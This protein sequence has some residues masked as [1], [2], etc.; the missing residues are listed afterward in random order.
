MGK[1]GKWNGN[2]CQ[3]LEDLTKNKET[4]NFENGGYTDFDD[5]LSNIFN[6][7]R[8][9][10]RISG[11]IRYESRKFQIMGGLAARNIQNPKSKSNN[12]NKH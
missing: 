3:T 2:I 9:Q 8:Q 1:N 5:S 12:R 10:H 7:Q 4:Y 6:S 11:G